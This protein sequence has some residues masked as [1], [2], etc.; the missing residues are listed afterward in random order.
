M[1]QIY[2][3]SYLPTYGSLVFNEN[4]EFS[5]FTCFQLFFSLCFKTPKVYRKYG[6]FHDNIEFLLFYRSMEHIIM[7]FERFDWLSH[8]SI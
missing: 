6:S 3:F 2:T 4:Q 8:H 5:L 7:Q 1:A